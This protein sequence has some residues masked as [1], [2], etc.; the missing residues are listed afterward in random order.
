[1]PNCT[2]EV[3]GKQALQARYSQVSVTPLIQ[4]STGHTR[5]DVKGLC[6]QR[7]VGRDAWHPTR[8]S[9]QHVLAGGRDAAVGGTRAGNG[10]A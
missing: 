9:K 10:A 3:T 5:L 4:D 6:L 2:T 1:M 7:D 8:D